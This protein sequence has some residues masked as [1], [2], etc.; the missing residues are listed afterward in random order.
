M[1]NFHCILIL[2]CL[3][4]LLVFTR[5]LTGKL[6][7]HECLILRFHP[8][9]ENSMHTKITWFTV[10]VVAVKSCCDNGLRYDYKF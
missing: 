9:R 3:S 4:V 6:N 8:T 1:Y 7:F 2:C 10:V 5:S